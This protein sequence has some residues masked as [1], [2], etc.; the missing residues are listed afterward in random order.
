MSLLVEAVGYRM[1][2][3]C[4]FVPNLD[5]AAEDGH[6]LAVGDRGHANDALVEVVYFD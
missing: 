5:V 4:E 2:T 3:L 1:G 6:C